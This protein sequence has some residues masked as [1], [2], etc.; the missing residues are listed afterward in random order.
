MA[1]TAAVG[2]DPRRI[3]SRTACVFDF[4]TREEERRWRPARGRKAL[5][6]GPTKGSKP[7]AKIGYEANLIDPD[8]AWLRLPTRQVV[9][10]WT[11]VLVS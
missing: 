4:G 10:Q 7:H 3:P 11:T 1:A 2:R 6:N 9:P 5:G 8:A